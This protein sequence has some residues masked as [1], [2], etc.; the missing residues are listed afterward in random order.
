MNQVRE[1]KFKILYNQKNITTYISD[2]LKSITYKDAV[3]GKSDE[4]EIELSNASGKWIDEW[5]PTFGDQLN[6]MMG[7]DDLQFPCGVFDIDEVEIKWL[8][9]IIA[10][11][12]LAAGIK[13][14][15]RTK[16]SDS[17]ENKTLRQIAQKIA[18]NHG[19]VIAGTIDVG[20]IKR[21]TQNR[22]TDLGFLK[23]IS[24]DY[25]HIFSIRGNVI[26][27]TDIYKLEGLAPVTTIDRDD[28]KSEGCWI[29]D[30]SYETYKKIHVAYHNPRA[31]AV[32]E[33]EFE[34]PEN[35][36]ID[37]YTWNSIVKKDVKEVR[38]KLDNVNQADAK[39]LAS[40]HSSNSKQQEG[41]LVLPGNPLLV[42]GNNFTLTGMG[43]LSGVYHIYASEHKLDVS[44]GYITE[45]DIKR[46]GFIDVVKTK[47]KVK[48]RKPATQAIVV[49]R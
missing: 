23:R 28:L 34:F 6:V 31:K 16:N 38:V 36:N 18:D 45:I 8:P 19:Y 7:Y 39:A 11:K 49:T 44:D 9:D 26:T 4:I 32:F 13:T 25:G 15:T 14:A 30:K 21:V 43:K 10:I 12:G 41:R 1:P 35:A 37:N 27:F 42:S 5:Y 29:K 24:M 3:Q 33:T 47:R 20:Q 46:V 22:E 17:H 48:P 2:Y 40:L